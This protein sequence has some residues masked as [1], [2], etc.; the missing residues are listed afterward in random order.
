MIHQMAGWIKCFTTSTRTWVWTLE[1]TTYTGTF[2][3]NLSERWEERDMWDHS[4]ASFTCS[5][6]RSRPMRDPVSRTK[7]DDSSWGMTPDIN[8]WLWL[9][10]ADG[11]FTKAGHWWLYENTT[12]AIWFLAS[13]GSLLAITQEWRWLLF[14]SCSQWSIATSH[15]SHSDRPRTEGPYHAEPPRK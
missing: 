2:F 13:P 1:K 12:L 10:C 5:S 4:P 11:Y 7:S 6:M 3:R 14:G 8:L 15:A 9:V